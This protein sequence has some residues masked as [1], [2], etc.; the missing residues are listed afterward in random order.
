[1][2]NNYIFNIENGPKLVFYQDTTKH[3]V[4]A[5]IMIRYGGIHRDFVIDNQEYHMED[6]MA[7]FLE[8]LLIEHSIYGNALTDFHNHYVSCNGNTST[9]MTLYYIDTV[10][11]FEENLLKLIKMVNI[12]NFTSKD[13]DVT[14][15][16]V[17]EEI[18][19][20]ADS[21]FRNLDIVSKRCLFHNIKHSNNIGSEAYIQSLEYNDVKLCYDVFYQPNNQVIAICGN[22][23]IDKIKELIEKTYNGLT[24]KMIQY[25][26]P[27][28]QEPNTVAKK[29]DILEFDTHQT[30]TQLNYKVDISYFSNYEKVKGTFYLDYFLKY[31]FGIAS[32]LYKDMVEHKITITDIDISTGMVDK[33]LIIEIGAFT[34]QSELFVKLV[35]EKMKEKSF[36]EEDFEIRRIKSIISLVLREES[37]YEMLS[38]F[39]DN[40]VTFGYDDIDKIEDIESYTYEDYVHMIEQLDFS[41]YCIT[42]IVNKKKQ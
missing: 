20:N 27:C 4:V 34:E 11:D 38:A 17:I 16:A 2:K 13:I 21:K 24:K 31:N 32:D 33:F 40:I 1:M 22:F 36:D 14:K 7:H 3:S 9:Y 6:G 10:H 15:Y 42:H 41:N 25:T 30:Y 12:P 18:R 23:D 26:I 37:P 8:H 5:N 19:K 35:Q 28:F 39:V 29:E